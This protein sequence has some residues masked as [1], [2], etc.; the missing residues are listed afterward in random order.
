[1]SEPEMPA[2]KIELPLQRCDAFHSQDPDEVQ[3]R[4][5]QKLCPHELEVLERGARLDAHF[6]FARFRR[7]GL[8]YV[9]YG[10]AVRVKPNVTGFVPVQMHLSGYGKARCGKQQICANPERV[11]VANY[12]EPLEM[13]LS[14]NST[15]LLT[16]LEWPMLVEASADMMGDRVPLRRFE[17]GMDAGGGYPRIWVSLLVNLV[18]MRGRLDAACM[19]PLAA[20]LVEEL[21]ITG[22]LHA[23]RSNCS[24]HLAEDPRCSASSRLVGQ[25]TEMIDAAPQEPYTVSDMARWFNTSAYALNT[26]FRTCRGMTVRQYLRHARLQ[27]V[28]GE[29]RDYGPGEAT[30]DEVASRWGFFDL[31]EFTARYRAEFGETPAETLSRAT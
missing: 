12:D 1:M 30:V 20:P 16:R 29:L 9:Q 21:L 7:M 4:M 31:S 11:M 15:L 5:A 27:R 10:P 28:Y 14:R 25:V 3:E 2:S 23:A 8:M 13:W 19:N 24:G 26:A 17:L 22:L 18:R 6:H